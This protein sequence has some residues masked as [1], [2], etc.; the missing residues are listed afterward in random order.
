MKGL[1]WIPVFLA[2]LLIG[3]SDT[4]AE[5]VVFSEIMYHP[6]GTLPEYIEVC[7]NTATPLD[8]ADWQL[9]GG[10]EYVFPPFSPDAPDRTFLKP[11]ERIV[12][13][14]VDEPTLRAAY[15]VPPPVRV[16][17]P[18]EGNL[19]NG[20]E[21]ITLRDKNG[22]LVCAVE[23]NDR[24]RWSPAADGAGHSLVLRNPD[25]RIDDWH[26]W[27]VSGRPGGTPGS[28][29]VQAAETPTAD[30]EVNLTA[31]IPF[32]NYGDVWR[33][34]DKNVDLGTAWRALT[35]DDSDWPQGPGLFGFENAPLP[36]PGIRT[37]FTNSQQLTFYA[38]T[39]FTYN[40]SLKGVTITV[41]QVLDDGAVYYLNG[42]ELGR[43][44]MAPGPATFA[45]AANRTVS[46]AVEE[47]GIIKADGSALVNGTNVLA[48][49]VH[50]TSPSSSD[51][52]FGMR[53]SISAPTQ[54]SLQINEVLPGPA[55][56]GFVEIYNPGTSS[57]NLR[58][59]YFTDDPA[60]LRKS[61]VTTDLVVP[62][63]GLAWVGFAESGLA[64]TSPVKVYLVAPD[65]ET[66]I[67]AI[68]T[69]MPLDGRS[70]GRKPSGNSSWFLFSEPTR[71]APNTSQGKI[72]AEIHLNEVHFISANRVD[73]VELY[74]SS[75]EVVSLDG[76][77]L[78]AKADQS[79]KV[80][81]SGSIPAGGYTSQNVA[82]PVSAGEVT[83]FL[84]SS[85]DA[86]LAARVF[87]RPALGDCLQAFPQGSNDWY[88]STQSTRGAANS[89][90][91]NTNIVINEIMY[92][93]P[94]NEPS[95][96][97]I[98][99]YNRGTAA[100]DVSGWRFVDGVNFTIP[101]GTSIP[102]DGYLVVAADA[103]WVRA[104]YGNLSVVGDFDGQL[105]NQGEVVRL[106]DQ[107][108]NLADEV[109]Y[110]AGGNWPDLVRGGGSSMELRN[111]WMDNSLASAWSDS[112]ESNRMPF[113][114]YS[115]T[116]T[117]R[118]LNAFGS[119]TDY[120][121]LHFYLVGDS[122]V[123]LKNIQV[124]LNGMGSN[125]IVNGDKMSTDGRSANGWLAQG[126]HYASYIQNGELHIIADGHGDNR[127]NRI[128]IDVTAMQ[129]NQKYEV[130]FD[131][132]W[133]SG[134]SR[135][136]VETFDHSIGTSIS[137]P[138]S[139]NIGTP[140]ARNSSFIP[141]P[142]PQVDGLIHYPPVPA[143]GQTVRVTAHVLSQTPSPQVLLFHR[144][145]NS[146]AS[147]TWASKPMV[148]D[149]T[150]G[151]EQA[152]D[153]IYTA[154]LTE[155]RQSGQVVQFYVR[156][157]LPNNQ[158]SQLPREGSD[159]PAMY[160]ID[161]SIPA[162]D[163]RRM[164][165]VVSA[166]DVQ[167][168]S[169]G[170]SSSGPHGYAFPRL[171]NHHFNAT[172]IVNEKDVIYGCGIRASGSP[173]TRSGGLD[174]AKY[175]LPRDALFRGKQKLVYRTYDVGIVSRDRV[176][177]YWLYLLGN[178]ANENEFIYVK[179]N[180]GGSGVREEME[181][182]S[183][184]MLD[185]AYPNGS[186]GELYKVDDEW[187]FQ[188]NW[189]RDYRDA[190]WSYKSSDNADRY[191]SE[192]MKRTKE[193]EDDYTALISFFKK[194]NGSYTQAEIER[195]VDPVAVLK[196][197]AVAGYI[198]AW[199][200]ISVRRGK[201]C[202]FYRRST[203]GRLMCFPWD[204]K[205]SFDNAG[206]VFYK[207]ESRTGVTPWMEKSYNM[208]LFK[209]YLIR[210]IENYTT[211]SVRINYW[212]QLEE[213]ASSQYDFG[214]ASYTSW[215]ASRQGSA[216]NFL[217][218]SRSMPFSVS[219][220]GRQP[221]TTGANTMTLTGVA[222]LRVFKV[223]VVD[224]PEAQFMWGSESGWI[225]SGVL[226]RAGANELTV[227]GVDEFGAVL[228]EDK[229][230]V[231]KTGNAPPVM[232]VAAD[233]PAWQALVS[234]PLALDASGSYDP[235]GEPL[236]YSW[237][238]APSGA[239]LDS[240]D[241][242]A[243]TVG[244]SHPDIYTFALAG[245]DANGI[246]TTIQRD[247][248][249]YGPEGLSLFDPPRLELFWNLE[250]VAIRTNYTTGPYY[251]LTEL[252][253]SLILQVWNSDGVF[254][255]AGAAPKYPLIW[256]TVPPSTDWAFLSRLEL[257]G[258]VFGDYITGILAEIN[259]GGSPVRYV[260]GI[261]DGSLV[262]VRR[263]AASG[264]VSLL[265]SS[266]WNVSTAELRIRRI[267]DTLSFE[268]RVNNVW[269]SRHSTVLP[270]GS[271]ALKAGMVLATDT[272]QSVKVAFDDAILVDPNGGL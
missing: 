226:L 78:T 60:N 150:S 217:G 218:S 233:P 4:Q 15:N 159:R 211:N 216:F 51:V 182:T 167:D 251:S 262:N 30:P 153:G 93:P 111:P 20:G 223:Q 106:V 12:L 41:D 124:R 176:V 144:L 203:D 165:F 77:S 80:P 38:R 196:A 180:N 45:T 107:W 34:N 140:G 231:N 94:S 241:Q 17:G 56:A 83:L 222:P 208:R 46:D 252:E 73:W 118:E 272:A 267:G 26:N 245:Q 239:S 99:L 187:W 215:F 178:P 110:L 184:D 123:I 52:V 103:N 14:S 210:L 169:Q 166:L 152:G 162:G 86:V 151:D 221:V 72:A 197:F 163:L 250:N 193:N 128:E 146:T 138:V 3:A 269:I 142:A 164:R 214:T 67:N 63:G 42:Q 32:V 160:V 29:E 82:F 148:D 209:H 228:H 87:E 97:F 23:Y 76:M 266:P 229:V 244:F 177:R 219:G 22:S 256:R 1:C 224:H 100:V 36:A 116:D 225:L 101:A 259:E 179:I 65:G 145:D 194:V 49:E 173:W 155:Y 54:A 248:I 88:A 39:K 53:L 134:A 119:V 58:D 232:V 183:N 190:D 137:L 57:I 121:E 235:E 40:G 96:E 7:N 172:L 260:F 181:P 89:P 27:T 158:A 249:I 201:N 195:I 130:S 92:D 48:V 171:S 212:M 79:G 192:W 37:P 55:G 59:Y 44:G 220:S 170:D 122:H 156:A 133:V 74:N 191:R 5:Q 21:R 198:H 174:R 62:A 120:R 35:F 168:M 131:A 253:G 149:G 108:G 117:Y 61:C 265:R 84:V 243:V 207:E 234:E 11:F 205:R 263:I 16:W 75:D 161:T 271:I 264:A 8:I 136:I 85:A 189:N 50:Q 154:Q 126:T 237:S 115:Y 139:A 43:S 64:V 141:E 135:L 66:I 24:G 81:L 109:D 185:R 102:Q 28:E 2:V 227:Q 33:Y 238:V 204:M 186:Q 143:P 247:A 91:R 213:N 236:Q 200:F 31:G 112:D 268:Q 9:S 254:P 13:S 240:N 129:P 261:E 6:P 95:A 69:L 47:L 157:S 98:E 125:L 242:N 258:Q 113:Q 257:R 270:A 199:D 188:D 246:A 127:P 18:W 71:G 70:I 202:S 147:G 25:R 105:S 114:H 206:A 10:V 230:T 19:N 68:S 175:E 132:R 255:M 90:A 104:T